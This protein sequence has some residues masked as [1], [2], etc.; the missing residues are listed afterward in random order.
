MWIATGNALNL[1]M[2]SL[3]D[4]EWFFDLLPAIKG[5][6]LAVND[7]PH[8]F[9]GQLLKSMPPQQQLPMLGC[10]VLT[11]APFY[12]IVIADGNILTYN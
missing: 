1:L 4:L 10:M 7:T 6:D 8:G 2:R 3:E 5:E 11:T 9:Q 12:T